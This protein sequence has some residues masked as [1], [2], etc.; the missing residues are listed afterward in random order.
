NR[1]GLYHV[2]GSERLSRYEFALRVAEVFGLDASLI[3]RVLSSD[4]QQSAPRPMV[5]GFITLKAESQLGLKPMD[6]TQGLTLMKRER[7]TA[8]D[9]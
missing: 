2:C 6:T 9:H 8:K 3:S 5:T 7:Q 4:L 1:D